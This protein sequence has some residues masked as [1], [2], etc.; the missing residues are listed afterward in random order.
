NGV[1]YNG[2]KV[3]VKVSKGKD[4][5]SKVTFL[6]KKIKGESKEFNKALKAQ[7]LT[8][9]VEIV[10]VDVEKITTSKPATY[11]KPGTVYLKINKKGVAKAWLVTQ[12]KAD[13]PKRSLVRIKD[14]V[15]YDSSTKTAT[16][17]GTN[18]KGSAKVS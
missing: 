17:T 1:S 15:S 18:V 8:Y 4:A 12:K 5:G 11:E 7:K 10:P 16:F 6:I 9:T 14:G 3:V 2:S 13:S